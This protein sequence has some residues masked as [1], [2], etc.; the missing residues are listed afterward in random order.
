MAAMDMSILFSPLGL[1][2]Q[3]KAFGGDNSKTFRSE[4]RGYKAL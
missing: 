2:D 4:N 1:R 3:R